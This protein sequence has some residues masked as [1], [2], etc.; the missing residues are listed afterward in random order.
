M[1]D[2]GSAFDQIQRILDVV[3]G[4]D[5]IAILVKRLVGNGSIGIGLFD[6]ITVV[7]FRRSQERD[8]F[9]GLGLGVIRP[10]LAGRLIRQ[11]EFA[12]AWIRFHFNRLFLTHRLPWGLL[13]EAWIVLRE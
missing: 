7:C 12:L 1:G 4:I 9:T 3:C 11:H 2:S 10:T 6:H 5:E 8:R 13:H